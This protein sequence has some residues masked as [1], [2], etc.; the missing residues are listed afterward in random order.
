MRSTTDI[1]REIQTDRQTD[2][3]DFRTVA[4][5]DDDDDD[6]DDELV[7]SCTATSRPNDANSTQRV[8]ADVNLAAVLRPVVACAGV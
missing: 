7:G 6:D 3:T 2:E 5:D 1:R 8:S 4:A